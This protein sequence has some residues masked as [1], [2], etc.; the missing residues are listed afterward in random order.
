MEL[1]FPVREPSKFIEL[2][3][4][5]RNIS[6]FAKAKVGQ[7]LG[8]MALKGHQMRSTA[9][10]LASHKDSFCLFKTSSR[11]DQNKNHFEM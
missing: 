4:S 11:L 6:V 7:V 3:C 5:I 2:Y 10:P 9:G 1:D 8:H